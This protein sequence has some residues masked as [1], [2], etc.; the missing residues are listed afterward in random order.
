MTDRD[1]FEDTN[2]HKKKF[3]CRGNTFVAYKFKPYVCYNIAKF[4][5]VLIT[6]SMYNKMLNN[7]IF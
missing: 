2:I 5:S 3:K 7:T 6:I 1:N 4:R